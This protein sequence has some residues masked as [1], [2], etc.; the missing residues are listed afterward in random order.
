MLDNQSHQTWQ[1]FICSLPFTTARNNDGKE[2]SIEEE[3]LSAVWQGFLQG[4]PLERCLCCALE[5]VHFV[6]RTKENYIRDQR[7]PHCVQVKDLISDVHMELTRH[8]RFLTQ[9]PFLILR[10]F[11]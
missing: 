10:L 5:R 6:D 8:E 2:G 1:M 11:F 9:S 7:I 3:Q 4:R